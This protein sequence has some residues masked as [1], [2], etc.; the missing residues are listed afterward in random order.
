MENI[1][2]HVP[3][4]LA[5]PATSSFTQ[6][7]AFSPRER[8]LIQVLSPNGKTS[9]HDL[10]RLIGAEHT[11]DIVLHLRRKFGMDIPMTKHK[12]IDRDGKATYPGYYSLSEKDM[13]H[14][15]GLID[16]ELSAD[17]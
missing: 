3:K 1:V 11:P 10:D 13:L 7:V 12:F 9:R 16:P 5:H 6:P 15:P 2:S 14:V 17:L 4:T 8:R